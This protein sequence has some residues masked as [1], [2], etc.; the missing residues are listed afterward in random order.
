MRTR[1][2]HGQRNTS[3]EKVQQN[4]QKIED[5]FVA[6]EKAN[7]IPVAEGEQMSLLDEGGMEKVYV[8]Q[9]K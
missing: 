7:I 6:L 1:T 5:L 8:R 3:S 4:L 9:F 2:L